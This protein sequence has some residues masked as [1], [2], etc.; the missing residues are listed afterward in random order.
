MSLVNARKS[1][2]TPVRKTSVREG[3]RKAARKQPSVF[4][5]VG[6]GASAGG[7]EAFTRLLK[8]FP[9]DANIGLVL[10][11]HLDPAHESALTHLLGKVTTMPTHE[12]TDNLRVQPNHVYVIPPNR[13]LSI[14]RGVLKLG[15]RVDGRKPPHAV[16]RFLE[17]L[18]EDQRE[19][20]IGVI[21]SGTAS[22]GTLGLEAIKAEGGITFAQ[23]ESAKYDSMPR[24]AV[25]AG[26][27]DFVLSPEKIADELVRIA[28]HPYVLGGETSR[29]GGHPSH[30]PDEG[31]Q[32]R[33]QAT[34]H[35]HDDS[36]LPSG[37]QGESQLAATKARAEAAEGVDEPGD[38]G[39]KKVMLLLR[40]HS[41]VD[42][43]LYKSNTIRRR[44]ARRMVL[45]KHET[46]ADYARFLK[47]N[48]SELDTLFSDVLISVTSFFRNPDSFGVLKRDIIP[49]ILKQ[50]SDPVR[51][52]VLGCSTGQE[53]YSVAMAYW[54]VMETI[55][56]RPALQIFATDLNERLL[57]KARAGLYSKSLAADI[58][59]ER[60]RRFFV[61]EDGGY[62]VVKSIR[63]CVVFARQN[64]IT[65]PPFSRMDLICCR[66]LLIYLEP[67]LQQRALPTFHYALKPRGYLF[68]G[69]SE[70]IGP[71][72]DL[73]EVVDKRH[74]I[75]AKKPVQTPAQHLPVH[76]LTTAEG[77]TR[78][79]APLPIVR[80]TAR[81][82]F[83]AQREADRVT[84]NEFAPPAVLVDS[85][86]QI[87]QFRGPTAPYL[88]PPSGKASFDLLKMAREGLMLPLR[89]AINKA[90]KE[91]TVVR[92]EGVRI[93]DGGDFR[94]IDV[95]VVPLRN[96]Q[97]QSFLVLFEEHAATGARRAA[98]DAER[99]PA[100]AKPSSPTVKA[101][102]K[103]LADAERE[104]AETRDYVQAIQ[105]RY[106]SATEEM[107]AS[108]EEAQSAN[109]ELQSIN[110]ELETSKE[111]LESTNEELTTVN[112]EMTNRNAELS[113]ANADLR[114]LHVSIHT[115]IVVVGR[116]LTIR[117]F[118]PLAE[119]I[120]SVGAGDIGRPLGGVSRDLGI[121]VAEEGK[122]AS[123]FDLERAMTEVI[124][125]VSAHEREVQ[126]RHGRWYSLRIRPYMTMEN[127]VDGAVMAL[128]DIDALKRSEQ[129]ARAARAVSDTVLRSMPVPLLVLDADLLVQLANEAF[130]RVFKVDPRVTEGSK[131]YDLGNGQWEIP[132]LRTLLEGTLR[133]SSY[134]ENFEV[135]H[136]FEDIGPRTMR[137]NARRLDTDLG[138]PRLILLAI[139]DVSERKQREE[140]IRESEERFRTAMSSL[141]EGLYIVDVD[142]RLL[143]MNAAAEKMLGWTAADLRGRVMHEAVHYAHSSGAPA[144]ACERT[145]LRVLETGAAIRAQEDIFVRK[146]GTSFP[147]V[148]SAS[149]VR[150][151]DAATGIVV[152]F[153]DD[154]EFRRKEEMLRASAARF[155]ALAE[156]VPDK[157]FT[158]DPA[159]HID[160]LSPQW[161]AYTGLDSALF[162]DG[163]ESEIVHPEDV[164]ET[165]R[166]WRNA[167]AGGLPF[168]VE[169]RL[170]RADGEYRWHDTRA[171]PFRDGDRTQ[172]WV[173]ASSDIQAL[174][175]SDQRKDEFLAMLAHELRNPLA[176]ISNALD[177][178]RQSED[179]QLTESA[180]GMLQRQV[181][182]VTR[183]VDDLLDVS[184]ISRGTI[185]LH[186]ERV[187]LGPIV[188]QAVEAAQPRISSRQQ[189]FT[190]VMPQEPIVL[191]A[192]ATRLTQVVGNLL[193]NA[194]KFT[195]RG[196]EIRLVVER[197]ASHISICVHDNGIGIP[198]EQLE[199]IFEMF[200]QVDTSLERVEGG[201][202][203]GLMLVKKLVAMHRGTVEA[204]SGGLGQGSRFIIRLPLAAEAHAPARSND[205]ARGE[206]HAGKPRRILVADDNVD[207]AESMALLLQL[208]GHDVRIAHDGLAA[209]KAAESF[210]PEIVLLDIG[211]P[212]LNGYQ[213]A[214]RIR[215]LDPAVRLVA[216]SGYAQEEDRIQSKEAGFA[217]HLVKPVDTRRLREFIAESLS[218][219]A[220]AGAR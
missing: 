51:V 48:T 26:C 76:H 130:Y 127:R 143:Y 216:V 57:E 96:L 73:F 12:V 195:G 196:G 135:F 100:P 191:D 138:Q 59:P 147:V 16:D 30:V 46:L 39:F 13:V 29:S 106:D 192:D 155:R 70:S 86:L 92:K 82:E 201:L 168:H 217:L 14:A 27:V 180:I 193:S 177:I 8:N 47:G 137:L 9:S 157:I 97:E 178:L 122:A 110:E 136:D 132:A 159:G 144:P 169:H 34:A 28:R 18:A 150:R 87:V 10:V 89:A 112:E 61:E 156:T 22:D 145:E 215:K 78:S 114:N 117:H 187:E 33:E 56:R 54:E 35:E 158:A 101:L 166:R 77:K 184:R 109:E 200:V 93:R 45:S 62:R 185:G 85:G 207:A 212:T 209:V 66:N 176:P 205:L 186:I 69:A 194:S 125:S 105:D 58:S 181:G 68:L 214:R 210:R 44:I 19:R 65:D 152:A 189:R 113:R 20:A 119:R 4:P 43:T 163:A 7:L 71:Y 37:G 36:P 173:G 161:S 80:D 183:L 118:T 83:S 141:A 197:D 148:Y 206:E 220:G 188:A 139:D 128:L 3:S 31:E 75:F 154:T 211:M 81:S 149:A 2:K 134:F 72:T 133:D 151:G 41:G 17:S 84:I 25:A 40:N 42:F 170:R 204:H 124:D 208:S 202:G 91:N 52:W 219:P 53:A 153:R 107:Q 108:N 64:L 199:R 175:E 38:E 179:K 121:V 198:A 23:D 90:R 190:L 94:E 126:D 142:G 55:H 213:A 123:P 21:L 67:T 98:R 95:Q 129:T 162:E 15:P 79:V 99:P 49:K 115:A 5:I 111:E 167:I 102:Q 60:L 182:Q 160:Y 218:S 171:V 11:Q 164:G 120:F 131:I 146:D 172:M 1:R 203:I 116:D 50:H 24:S 63:D 174:K 140:V 104:L 32:A 103:R 165:L 6:V 88:T 74:K